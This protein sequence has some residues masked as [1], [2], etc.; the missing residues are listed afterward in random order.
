[1]RNRATCHHE[2]GFTLIELVIVMGI[3]AILIGVV[4]ISLNPARQF[5]SSRNTQRWSH[6]NVI[7]NSIG[8]NSA[9]NRGIFTCAIGPI[10]TST[11]VL[12][13]SGYDIDTCI[14]PT[15]IATLPLDPSTGTSTD[16]GYSI[17]RN[18][19]SGRVTVTA[20]DAELEETISVIR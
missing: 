10:P 2:S 17:V 13:T 6:V 11:T 3:L 12:G 5:A 8:Q 1:M 14:T 19:T 4:V 20:D 18:P 9:D 15:Y 16:I 7:L